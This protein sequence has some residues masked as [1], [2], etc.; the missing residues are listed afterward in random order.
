MVDL[1][2]HNKSEPVQIKDIAKQE[3]LSIR[4][5]EN[6]FTQLRTVGILNRKKDSFVD[7]ILPVNHIL[8]PKN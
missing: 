6:I 4:Y 8:Q 1:T 7:F 5:L 2:V 3:K